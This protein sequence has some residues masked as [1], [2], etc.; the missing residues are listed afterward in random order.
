MNSFNSKPSIGY[1][2]AVTALQDLALTESLT[3][4]ER[5]YAEAVAS[6]K[7]A[8]FKFRHGV[9]RSTRT[10]S[11][12]ALARQGTGKGFIRIPEGDHVK[13]WQREG[14]LDM[15]TS[16]PYGLCLDS[17]RAM[18][19]LADDHGINININACQSVHFPGMTL[20]VVYTKAE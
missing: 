20:M 2:A 16:E 19:R 7:M 4:A 5:A 8:A 15:I 3:V 18:V 1:Q 17:L 9:K 14:K 6:L 10:P 11:L 12:R 13:A